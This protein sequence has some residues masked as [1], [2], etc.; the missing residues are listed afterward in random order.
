MKRLWNYLC[1]ALFG[2]C[3]FIIVKS[4][5][6]ST[7]SDD[8]FPAPLMPMALIC[9]CILGLC[10]GLSGRM[11]IEHCLMWNAYGNR[12]KTAYEAKFGYPNPEF[13]KMVDQHVKIM[14]SM[15]KGYTKDMAEDWIKQM[16]KFVEVPFA[17]PTEERLSE[18]NKTLLYA[19]NRE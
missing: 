3:A 16:A 5:V 18:K 4:I 12:L 19:E 17:V 1:N 9:G 14:E 15:G 13:N 6:D 7:E 10:K 8:L 11:V 2:F